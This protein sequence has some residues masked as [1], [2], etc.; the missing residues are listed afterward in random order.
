MTAESGL[1][2]NG[3]WWVFG[4]GAIGGVFLEILKWWRIRDNDT[5]DTYKKSWKYWII[6]IAMILCGGFWA[7][8]N[9]ITGIFAIQALILGASAPLSFAGLGSIASS[10]GLEKHKT[11]QDI[12]TTSGAYRATTPIIT[13]ES[14]KGSIIKFLT[15]R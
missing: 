9:G 13:R 15:W 14:N 6:T 12:D 5:F 4:T 7:C 11:T 1:I 8:L 2:L 10:F 3:F